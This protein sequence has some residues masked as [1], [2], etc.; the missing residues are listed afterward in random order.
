MAGREGA[1][2]SR[3]ELAVMKKMTDTPH[4][5]CGTERPWIEFKGDAG[6]LRESSST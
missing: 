3:A 5:K 2:E 4:C 1:A 6:D